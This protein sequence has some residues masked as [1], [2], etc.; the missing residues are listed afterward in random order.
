MTTVLVIEDDTDIRE[1]LRLALEDAGY[2]VLEAEDAPNGLGLLQESPCPLMVL[3][4]HLLPSMTSEELL[5]HASDQATRARH[6]FAVITASPQ[7]LT[8]DYRAWLEV[9]DIPTIPKPFE[10]EHLLD[11]VGAQAAR[12]NAAS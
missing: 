5:R 3:V 11:T 12:L 8:E 7:L 4:D 2:S 1:T 6:V 9:R 10:L